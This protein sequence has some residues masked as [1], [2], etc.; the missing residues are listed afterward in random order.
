MSSSYE[1]ITKDVTPWHM[2]VVVMEGN[3]GDVPM[4]LT[5]ATNKSRCMDEQL[6]YQDKQTISQVEGSGRIK[7]V[8]VFH[9]ERL[10][11]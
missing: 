8:R 10:R 7:L 1:H 4:T 9:P 2:V 3:L 11:G 5:F 6:S